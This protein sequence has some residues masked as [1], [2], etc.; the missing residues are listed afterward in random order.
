[1]SSLDFPNG[2]ATLGSLFDLDEAG[3]RSPLLKARKLELFVSRSPSPDPTQVSD[4]LH[5]SPGQSTSNRRRK[6]K[7]SRGDAVL[8][9]YMGNYRNNDIGNAASEQPLS[10]SSEDEVDEDNEDSGAEQEIGDGDEDEEQELEE[11][12]R[13]SDES[14]KGDD[15]AQKTRKI[16]PTLIRERLMGPVDIKKE[17]RFKH[18]RPDLDGPALTASPQALTGN[19]VPGSYS[20]QAVATATLALTARQLIARPDPDAMNNE[21]EMVIDEPCAIAAPTARPE[22]KDMAL[23]ALSLEDNKKPGSIEERSPVSDTDTPGCHFLDGGNHPYAREYPETNTQLRTPASTGT[24]QDTTSMAAVRGDRPVVNKGPLPWATPSSISSPNEHPSAY[25]HASPGFTTPRL[26][27][28][29]PPIQQQCEYKYTDA[30][31]NI[32]PLSPTNINSISDNATVLPPFRDLHLPGPD[33]ASDDHRIGATPLSDSL[34][35]LPSLSSMVYSRSPP[36][37][38]ISTFRRNSDLTSPKNNTTGSG[39]GSFYA[40]AYTTGR[41]PGADYDR[42][43]S[44]IY[45]TG[46]VRPAPSQAHPV[47]APAMAAPSGVTAALTLAPVPASA[48]SSV[49]AQ[50]ARQVAIQGKDAPGTSEG[51]KMPIDVQT[52]THVAQG[53]FRCREPGCLAPPFQT[54]YLLNSH[55]NVHSSARPHYCPV[56]GCPRNRPGYG[57]KRKNEMIR[58]GLVHDSPGYICPFCPDREHKYPRPDN[59]QR[60]V[61]AHHQEKP[62]D[63]PQLRDVLAQ[64]PDGAPQRRRRRLA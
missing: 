51:D 6:V 8:I 44:A 55:A 34:G 39:G 45:R 47:L 32:K 27:N 56:N 7:P 23:G 50:A 63:D 28:H 38:P 11:D 42:R 19:G 5:T 10:D 52:T 37:S 4:S 53:N 54:Q 36:I 21:D 48:S 22:L 46:S 60:H 40:P 49:P 1:M 13:M 59:L 2:A 33:S 64:R 62:K 35:R 14:D 29:L 18:D 30:K 61:R 26:P 25:P 24:P 9:Q 12:A 58:H 17:P 41:P 31:N 3:P 15:A 20:M 57:F 43:N 16:E